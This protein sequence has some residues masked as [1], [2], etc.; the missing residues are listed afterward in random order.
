MSIKLAVQFQIHPGKSQ[1]FEAIAQSAAER[2]RAEDAG[3]EQYHLFRSLDDPQHYVLLESWASA[4]ELDAHGSSPGIA[5]MRKV[6]P[7][8]AARPRMTRSED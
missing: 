2:V 7:L 6:A 8:L 1:E 4:A 3:C 5:E